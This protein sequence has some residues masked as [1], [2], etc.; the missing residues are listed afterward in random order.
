MASYILRRLW[1]MVPTLLGVILLI[2]FL[3]KYFGGDPAE[4]L[5]GLQATPEQIKSIR[6]QLGL[7]RPGFGVQLRVDA[8]APCRHG[9]QGGS[10]VGPGQ[11]QLRGAAH[12]EATKSRG[13]SVLLPMRQPLSA[14]A[15][16][17]SAS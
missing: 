12:S 9:E 16:T 7:D 5:G 10:V 2:F 11:Q 1:Q 3:F 13:S 4:I 6:N 8:M 14:S 15:S 17:L